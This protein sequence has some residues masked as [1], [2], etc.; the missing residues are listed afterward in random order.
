[1]ALSVSIHR[2]AATTLSRFAQHNN[3]MGRNVQVGEELC[4]IACTGRTAALQPRRRFAR[5]NVHKRA[6]SLSVPAHTRRYMGHANHAFFPTA[7]GDARQLVF[8]SS[9]AARYLGVSLA[10]IRRWTDAGH[11]TCYRTPGGQRRF[12]TRPARR[13]HR[14]AAARG[15]T[16]TDAAGRI[17]GKRQL[18]DRERRARQLARRPNFSRRRR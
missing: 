9:Q 2:T 7:A 14:L 6:R 12:S 18:G 1:M 8:T 3:G 13:L 4:T 17:A 5:P 16:H 10:T 11:I 15:S